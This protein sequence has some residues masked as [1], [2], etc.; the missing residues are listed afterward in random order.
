VDIDSRRLF[1]IPTTEII[2][3]QTM[4]G[5]IGA[6]IRRSTCGMLPGNSAA[7]DSVVTVPFHPPRA[8]ASSRAGPRE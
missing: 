6:G 5:N 4:A 8:V 3:G 1:H 7:S 2:R